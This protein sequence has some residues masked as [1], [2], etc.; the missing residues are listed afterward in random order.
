MADRDARPTDSVR[1]GRA[2]HAL[3]AGG[4]SGGHVFPALAVGEELVRRGWRVSFAGDPRGMEKR[5][6]EGRGVEFVPFAARPVVGRGA[7]RRA[8]ALA[9]ITRSAFGARRWLRREQVDVVVGTGGYASAPAA[10][11]AALARLPLVLIDPNARA[12]V[13][14]RWLSRFAAAAA[15]GWESAATG[16]RCPARVTGVPVRAGFAAV[17]PLAAGAPPRL[18]ALGGSQGSRRLNQ[19]LPGAVAAAR[20]SVPGLEVLHQCGERLAEEARAAWASAGDPPGVECVPFVADVAGAL[21]GASLVVS[22]AGAITLAEIAAAG[23]PAVLLPLALAGAHQLDN[24]RSF[25]AAGAGRVIE[26]ATAD[27]AALGRRLAE[28]LA[29]PAELAAM[30]ARARGLARP[31]AAAA[32]AD[33]AERVARRVAA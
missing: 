1:A 24:A 21:A 28:L 9:T 26:E 33:E 12:G 25:E 4:G 8:L 19:L 16:L 31:G 17:P 14:N 27:A 5:L 23:R 11:G 10:L 30:G 29:A 13:A 15:V 6:V 18:L 3:L 32:I 22:R 7:A 2:R 20:R